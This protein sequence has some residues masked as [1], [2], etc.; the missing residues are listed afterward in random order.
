MLTDNRRPHQE[1]IC[2]EPLEVLKLNRLQQEVAT[3][4]AESATLKTENG[5]LKSSIATKD[6]EIVSLKNQ[7]ENLKKKPVEAPLV[8]PANEPS[9]DNDDLAAFSADESNDTIALAEKMEKEGL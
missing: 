7:V 4:S 1:K 6:A 5:N 9:A 2:Y 3:L 8:K